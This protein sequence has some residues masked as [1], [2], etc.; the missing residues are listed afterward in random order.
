MQQLKLSPE[1]MRILRRRTFKV[2]F[3]TILTGILTYTVIM[4][5]TLDG[6]TYRDPFFWQVSAIMLVVFVV[7]FFLRRQHGRKILE[8]LTYYYDENSITRQLPTLPDLTIHFLEISNVVKRK[9]GDLLLYGL[10]KQDVIW[11][12]KEL[13]QFDAIEA[14]LREYMP[15]AERKPL[16][17]QRYVPIVLSLLVSS[18][19]VVILVVRDRTILAVTTIAFA[20]GIPF[21]A[22]QLHRSKIA[23]PRA[24]YFSYLFWAFVLLDAFV[25]LAGNNAYRQVLHLVHLQ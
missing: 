9:K 2:T 8:G 19:A 7:I 13:E 24:K 1:G 20:I 18:C 15:E 6:G 14:K 11:I 4:Y 22:I 10:T 25:K 23:K 3:I 12:P 5:F 21:M 17:W 16:T